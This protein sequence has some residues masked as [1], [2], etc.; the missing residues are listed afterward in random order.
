MLQSTSPTPMCHTLRH[1][2]SVTRCLRIR[3]RISSHST[4]VCLQDASLALQQHPS[5]A[6]YVPH[7]Y[8]PQQKKSC[9]CITTVPPGLTPPC[10]PLATFTNVLLSH[11]RTSTN[12]ESLSS[13][14][15]NTLFTASL[16]SGCISFNTSSTVLPVYVDTFAEG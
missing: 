9:Q 15:T 5:I 16:G 8:E 6:H 1:L 7:M 11:L 2:S 13:H 14:Y 4:M 3:V 12:S 10:I